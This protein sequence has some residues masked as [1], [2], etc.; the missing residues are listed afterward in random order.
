MANALIE[1]RNT[2]SK[3]VVARATMTWCLQNWEEFVS[4]VVAVQDRMLL[5]ADTHGGECEAHISLTTAEQSQWNPKKE[6]EKCS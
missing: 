1:I 4:D 3:E 6:A 2:H 5:N